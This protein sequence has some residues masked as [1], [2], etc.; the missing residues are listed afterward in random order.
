MTYISFTVREIEHE[1]ECASLPKQKKVTARCM[2]NSSRKSACRK[3][4]I[5][6][7]LSLR[8]KNFYLHAYVKN[9]EALQVSSA[10]VVNFIKLVLYPQ[11][12]HRQT[13]HIY[14]EITIK[15]FAEVL[16][17]HKI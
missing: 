13:R 10:I 7:A 16:P 11:E 1:K 15:Y 9:M 17:K 5:E 4:N 3:Q 2:L 14:D 8:K 6:G 12:N